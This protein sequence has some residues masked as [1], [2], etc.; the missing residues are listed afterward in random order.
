M[1]H[2]V[3]RTHSLFSA[4]VAAV[5]LAGTFV[6]VLIATASFLRLT[7]ETAMSTGAT[8]PYSTLQRLFDLLLGAVIALELAHSVKLMVT[9][10]RVYAQVRAVLVIGLLAVV[11]KLIVIEIEAVSGV[12]LLGLAGAVLALSGA[13]AMTIWMERQRGPT[14]EDGSGT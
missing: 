8:L 3:D 5:L 2:L 1:K 7:V 10:G 4:G 13:F 9:G 11:R 6:V 14:P 12:L